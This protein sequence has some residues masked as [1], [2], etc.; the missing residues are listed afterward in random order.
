MKLHC[1]VCAEMRSFEQPACVERHDGDCPEWACTA[2]GAA[3]LLAPPIML[4]DRRTRVV[5]RHPRRSA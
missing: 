1:D 2:C 4:V 3:I 5:M